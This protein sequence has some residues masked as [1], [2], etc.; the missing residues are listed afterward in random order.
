MHYMGTPI[1]QGERA[2]LVVVRSTLKSIGDLCSGVYKNERSRC[3]LGVD[4]SGPKPVLDRIKVGRVNSP[5]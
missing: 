1:P 5:P 4:S 3:R 2:I